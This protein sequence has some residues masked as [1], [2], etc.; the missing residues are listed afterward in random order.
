[1]ITTK[2]NSY[3]GNYKPTFWQR[4][5]LL[6]GADVHIYV[7][8]EAPRRLVVFHVGDRII[9]RSNQPE[10]LK[11]GVIIAEDAYPDKIGVVPVW[12]CDQDG[13]V[14][15]AGTLF[16]YSDSL[17]NSLAKLEWWEQWNVLTAGKCHVFTQ[18]EANEAMTRLAKER[19]VEHGDSK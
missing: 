12:R 19:E 8:R 14:Y 15:T 9:H 3:G 13:Q 2:I 6:L 16:P 1:M 10:A 11:T 18:D 4:I 5:A 7:E 17:M